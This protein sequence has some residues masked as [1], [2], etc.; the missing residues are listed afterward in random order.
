MLNKNSLSSVFIAKSFESCLNNGQRREPPVRG[1]GYEPF[2]CQK[3]QELLIFFLLITLSRRVDAKLIK[4][5]WELLIVYASRLDNTKN[6]IL[7]LNKKKLKMKRMKI[8]KNMT[9]N[10]LFYDE[11]TRFKILQIFYL[12]LQ[13]DLF[14]KIWK[15]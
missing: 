13:N 5:R 14:W 2:V 3:N 15:F 1:A 11:S 6:G 8:K 7:I 10:W 9:N 12:R 4:I